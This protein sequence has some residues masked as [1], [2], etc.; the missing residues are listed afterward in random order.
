MSNQQQEHLPPGQQKPPQEEGQVEVQPFQ[1]PSARAQELTEFFRDIERQQIDFLNE[2]GKSLIERIATFLVILL[3][4]SVL[5]NNSPPIYLEHDLLARWSILVAL[6]CYL[7]AMGVAMWT[8][9]P[10][11]YRRPLYNMGAL[12]RVRD[13]MTRQKM[14]GLRLASTLFL[15]GS[16]FLAVLIVDIVWKLTR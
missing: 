3:G 13:Q 14:R 4:A 9:Q 15:L 10:R 2:A 16:L 8:I 6:I 12:E 11:W 7:C 5:S 1:Q